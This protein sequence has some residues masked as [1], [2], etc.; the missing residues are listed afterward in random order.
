MS[1]C[2]LGSRGRRPPRAGRRTCAIGR[3]GAAM[4]LFN[5][6]VSGM[7]KGIA[8]TMDPGA[9]PTLVS[10]YLA[11]SLRQ[12]GLDREVDSWLGPGPNLPVSPEQL[13]NA[14]GEGAVEQ[15]VA[16]TGIPADKLLVL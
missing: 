14:L 6:V 7:V 9:I 5:K 11:K 10:Q 15:F 16:V 12:G 8:K 3:R 2:G 1:A 4:G 13:R